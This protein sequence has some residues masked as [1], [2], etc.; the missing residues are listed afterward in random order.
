MIKLLP[1]SH[2]LASF[3][4]LSQMRFERQEQLI[5]IIAFSTY[6]SM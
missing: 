5:S 2:T 1:P 6:G 3:R 4:S